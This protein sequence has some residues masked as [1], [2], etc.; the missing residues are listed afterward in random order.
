VLYNSGEGDIHLANVYSTET[1]LGLSE[2][3]LWVATTQ[4]SEMRPRVVSRH[5]SGG[6]GH[7]YFIVWDRSDGVDHDVEGREYVAPAGGPQHEFCSGWGG[8]PCGNDSGNN[9]GCANSGQPER[10]AARR[11]GRDL[12]LPGHVRAQRV[13]DARELDV[14][15]PPRDRE[16][17]PGGVRRRRRC[18]GGT[19]I[20]LKT[21]HNVNGASTYPA[22][23][24]PSISVRG[25]V[26]LYGATRCYQVWYRDPANYCTATTY[27]I[28]NGIEAVWTP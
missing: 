5:G 12:G 1:G 7:G 25:Q 8:C 13:G 4:D 18:V 19:L 22:A 21:L 2:N 3:M 16:P 17:A 11:D 28:S 26:P 24:D 23:G 20:R 15:L 10:G 6:T 14:H 27:N 9:N